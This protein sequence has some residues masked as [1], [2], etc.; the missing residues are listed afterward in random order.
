MQGYI[1]L[2]LTLEK[3]KLEPWPN[4]A[5]HF[6]VPHSFFQ[7]QDKRATGTMARPFPSLLSYKPSPMAE[8]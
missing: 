5:S 4:P 1:I 6:T 8:H 3:A 2:G 7:M